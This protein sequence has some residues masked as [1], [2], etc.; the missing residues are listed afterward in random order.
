[1]TAR[2]IPI[3]LVVAAV[4]SGI[5]PAHAQEVIAVTSEL[6]LADADGLTIE[7]FSGGVGQAQDP[8][9]PIVIQ[10]LQQATGT[11]PAGSAAS[12]RYVRVLPV[13]SAH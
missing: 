7:G 11:S 1:M 2:F 10:M 8:A 4:L 9:G 5:A 3:L 13:S 12:S 6:E